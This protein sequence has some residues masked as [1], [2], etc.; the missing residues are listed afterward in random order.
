MR[1]GEILADRF[2]VIS[3]AGAGGMGVVYRTH[4]R[5]TG[6]IV[7]MKVLGRPEQ[8]AVERFRREVRALSHLA[9][10]AIVRY[11]DSGV[12]PNG[13][14]YLAMEWL[15]GEDLGQR[16]ARD[17]V[18]AEETVAIGKRVLAALAFAHAKG[19]VHRDVKPTNVFLPGKDPAMAKVL[20]F[21]IARLDTAT[22]MM[23][24]TGAMLGS[25]GYMAPEQARGDRSVGPRSDLFSVGCVLFECLAG[26]P[27]FTGNHPITILVQALHDRPPS[28]SELRPDLPHALVDLVDRL[29]ARDP[30]DRPDSAAEALATLEAIGPLDS[31]LAAPRPPV[32]RMVSGNER[33]MVSVILVRGGTFTSAISNELVT[34]LA[35]DVDPTMAPLRRAVEPLG[36]HVIQLR[37]GAHLVLLE[38]RSAAQDEAAQAASCALAIHAAVPGSQ[39][40]IATGPAEMSG[41]WAA[42]PVVDRAL[43]LLDA[44][45][46]ERPE[47][48]TGDSEIRMDDVTSGLLDVR[49][50]VHGAGAM[51]ILAGARAFASES[52]KVLGKPTPCVGRER[53][54]AFLESTFSGAVE[55]SEARAVIAIAPAG[56]GKSRLRREITARIEARGARVL[57]A[58]CDAVYAGSPHHAASEL[59]RHAAGIREDDGAEGRRKALEAYVDEVFPPEQRGRAKDFLGEIVRAPSASEPGPLLRAAR[60]DPRVMAEQVREVFEAWWSELTKAEPLLVVLEDVHWSDASTSR[61]VEGALAKLQD[62]PLFVLALARPEVRDATPRPFASFAELSIEPLGKRAAERLV[63]A[64]LGKDVDLV[65]LERIVARAAGN[66]FYLE[67]L[68]RHVAAHGDESLPETVI[69]MARSRLDALEPEAR[70]VLRVGSVFGECMWEKGVVHLLGGTQPRAAPPPAMDPHHAPDHARASQISLGSQAS[71]GAAGLRPAEQ[72][73]EWLDTL[74]Q[75]EI[76]EPGRRDRFGGEADF[77]FRHALLRDAAYATLVDEDR[78]LGHR[79]AAEWLE[80]VGER[81]PQVLA[82]HHLRAGD[83]A[84]AA[85]HLLRAAQAR[86]AGG[87]LEGAATT[88]ERGLACNPEGETRGLLLLTSAMARGFRSDFDR[89]GSAAR[90]AIDLL[91]PGS[92]PWFQTAGILVLAGAVSGSPGAMFDLMQRLARL[93][94]PPEPSQPYAFTLFMIVTALVQLGQKD[95]ALGMGARLEAASAATDRTDPAF[96]GFRDLVRATLADK[97]KVDRLDEVLAFSASAMTALRACGDRL[98]EGIAVGWRGRALELAGAIDEAERVGREALELTERTNNALTKKRAQC[99]IGASLVGL[100]RYPEALEILSQVPPGDAMAHLL[101][102]VNIA[103]AHLYSGDLEAAR[104]EAA[105]TVDAAGFFAPHKASALG[106]LAATK[107]AGG[108]LPGALADARAGK[109]LAGDAGADVWTGT[110]VRLVEIEALAGMGAKT[111]SSIAGGVEGASGERAIRGPTTPDMNEEARSLAREA[112]ARVRAIAETLGV[113]STSF[114]S[115]REA[116]RTLALARSLEG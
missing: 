80:E 17:G 61:L 20:D 16:L 100:G 103:R 79:L 3:Q 75:R 51:R 115:G 102:R 8:E 34:V 37:Q 5:I 31:A 45:R 78:K 1:S 50:S 63:R 10:P 77:V 99:V 36:G 93:E 48:S 60:N 71:T 116:A 2:E 13:E 108:D 4:D 52:R 67:E 65:T 7:A 33:R 24:H 42:G 72:V 89:A 25:V 68:V 29:L 69:A 59:V 64:I 47:T 107:L 30:V 109:K 53:E 40:A 57:L 87:D 15:E 106:V 112:A 49:F 85:P 113:Y 12:T 84:R 96:E 38:G 23:T 19:V 104:R 46:P 86:M 14:P 62:R 110:L 6:S 81:D 92:I 66:A 9:H 70:R 41:R 97:A 114:V 56:V 83:D 90:E 39:V 55:E 105:A 43:A 32:R 98:G 111:E 74:T 44:T 101:A 54:L 18:T 21:G 11:V 94:S 88:A 26:R 95:M 73:R 22:R 35:S 27:T 91:A 82:E 76:L 58:R 28:M